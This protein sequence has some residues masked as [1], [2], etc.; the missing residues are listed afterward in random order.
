MVGF[1][2]K[3]W[4]NPP[5]GFRSFCLAA[6]L[7]SIC[8][9]SVDA[10]SWP[11]EVRVYQGSAPQLD[12]V[13]APGEYDDASEL[14]DFSSWTPEFLEVQSREDLYARVWLKHDGQSLYVAWDVTDDVLYG[15]DI[16]RYLPSNN[17]NAHALTREGFPWYGDGVELLVNAAYEWTPETNEIAAGTGASFMMVASNHKSLLGGLGVGGLM[18][19][20]PRSSDIAMAN[21]EEW[22][23]SG[24]IEAVV[25]QKDKATEGSGYIIE[26][27]VDAE[28]CL[29][30]S[31]GQFWSPDMGE[32]PMGLNITVADLD[33]EGV[34]AF[35]HHE[36]WWAGERGDRIRLWQFGTMVMVPGPKPDDAVSYPLGTIQMTPRVHLGL[37]EVAVAVP[38][39]YADQVPGDL[40]LKVPP[41]MGARVFAAGLEG[42]RFMAF[43][44]EGVLHVANMKGGGASQFSPPHDDDVIPAAADMHGQILALPDGNRDGIA[45]TSIVVV[46]NLWWATSLAFYQG[47]L[48]V[49]DRHAVRHYRDGDGDGVFETELDVIAELLFS[50]LHRTK[51]IVFNES[52]DKL[53][54]SVGSSCDH[55]RETDPERGTVLEFNA[56]GSGRRVFA[57]GLR[58]AVGLGI[59]PQ[60]NELWA[61]DNGLDK[62]GSMLPPESVRVVRDGSFHGWPVAYGYGVW[63]DYD[64]FYRNERMERTAQDSAAVASMIPPVGLLPA[65]TAPMAVHFYRGQALGANIQ[66]AA[67]VATRAGVLAPVAGHK[68]VAL[69]SE[70]DGSNP[71]MADLV[72][73]FQPDE[74]DGQSAWGEPTGIAEDERG[75]LFISSDWTTHVIIQIAPN[76]LQGSWEPGFPENAFVGDDVQ[77]QATV[78]ISQ[79]DP[80]GGPVT[81]TA[82]LSAWGGD[83]RQPL[84]EVEDGVF[85]L[86]EVVPAG[87]DVGGK[88]V[89]IQVEQLT[90]S[91]LSVLP[92]SWEVRVLRGSDLVVAD[93]DIPADWEVA[94]SGGIELLPASDEGPVFSGERAL[95]LRTG[96]VSGL[97]WRFTLTSPQSIATDEFGS[98]RFALHLGEAELAERRNPLSVVLQPGK[99]VDLIAD[100]LV[101][102]EN[103]QWQVVEVPLEAFELGG[104]PIETFRLF[105]RAEGSIYIDD[106]R[107]VSH[108]QRPP[109]AVVEAYDAMPGDFALGQNYPNPFN[110]A[111]VIP[112]TLAQAGEVELAV[113]DLLGQKVAVLA[114]GKRPAGSYEVRW[115]S[116]SQNG[117][118]LAS[119]IYLYRQQT[120]GGV[121][122]GK[123]VLVQ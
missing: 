56:D 43:S 69:F 108:F 96:N 41:G 53:Y 119:G 95:P 34:G 92:F 30:V 38:A 4:A 3:N 58:N 10:G 29:E 31:P 7:F 112:F 78:R 80:E 100:G 84:A 70:P 28:P 22:T 8:S 72:A 85:E 11:K 75:N 17:A 32:V 60:T 52:T 104:Q 123:L 89:Q 66:H 77:L 73:G 117:Y 20:E 67:L 13:I 47:D 87:S 26:W 109:T 81:V 91:G 55:C 51:T 93:E 6:L 88:G 37:E 65:H 101:D 50:D 114:S 44:P 116:R 36:D 122:V 111:T 45:D 42:P 5:C 64:A 76:L 120:T 68:V 35:L 71:Q 23:R 1:C 49:G 14:D 106:V 121:K 62:M 12:G 2:L 118:P 82:D 15:F 90:V 63:I 57:R 79:L 54:V 83:E 16:P 103:R 98:L 105:G 74:F 59:H 9:E 39:K 46:D 21:Y 61:T 102:P 107:L 110:G 33:E 25:R 115:D 48:Y 27:R 97:G 94:T 24:A 19:G 99:G 40:T 113:Y 86:D 18:L